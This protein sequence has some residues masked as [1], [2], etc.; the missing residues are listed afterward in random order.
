MNPNQVILRGSLFDDMTLSEFFQ[1]RR[2][3]IA[4]AIAFV[5][6]GARISLQDHTQLYIHGSMVI[7]KLKKSEP[8]TISQGIELVNTIYES[9][10][11]YGYLRQDDGVFGT[12]TPDSASTLSER[13]ESAILQH[14]FQRAEKSQSNDGQN[15]LLSTPGLKPALYEIHSYLSLCRYIRVT[16]ISSASGMRQL[17]EMSMRI[18]AGAE[19]R[20]TFSGAIDAVIQYGARRSAFWAIEFF[21][22][23]H[24]GRIEAGIHPF[25]FESLDDIY[26]SKAQ[27]LLRQVASD[28]VVNGRYRP[29]QKQLDSLNGII[30]ELAL[31]NKNHIEMQAIISRSPENLE[32]RTATGLT[33]HIEPNALRGHLKAVLRLIGRNDLIVG[34][35]KN[36]Q[37]VRG[38]LLDPPPLA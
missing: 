31:K 38:L 14:A 12:A 34:E 13:S 27:N 35:Q 11:K 20:Q 9:E 19:E 36:K 16:Q 5:E 21:E 7:D 10:V 29:K 17:V 3:D 32:Y 1:R 30:R 4:A 2:E 8:E 23:T 18:P 6:S 33:Q 26:K 24:R 15:N 22:C 28:G 25:N 37:G